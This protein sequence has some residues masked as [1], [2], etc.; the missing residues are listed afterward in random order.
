MKNIIAMIILALLVGCTSPYAPIQ[1]TY[2][3][4][5][6]NRGFTPLYQADS[7][8]TIIM[9]HGMCNHSTGWAKSR[10]ERL[11]DTM[12]LSASHTS[13]RAI[14]REFD[15]KDGKNSIFLKSYHY[16][17]DGY[18]LTAYEFTYGAFNDHRAYHFQDDDKH[19]LANREIKKLLMD[20]CLSDVTVY[21]GERGKDIRKALRH[22]LKEIE[23][24]LSADERVFFLA[25]SLGSKVLRDSLICQP[26][27]SSAANKSEQ[28]KLN[29]F[30]YSADAIILAS[31]QLPILNH[32]DSC[33][34][35]PLARR[36]GKQELSGGL[37]D[38]YRVNEELRA[39]QAD[40]GK[41][42]SSSGYKVLSFTDPNDLLSYRFKE[43]DFSTKNVQLLEIPVSNTSAFLNLLANPYKAHTGYLTNSGVVKLIACGNDDCAP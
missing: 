7:Q 38:M 40:E 19:A 5:Y 25:E 21:A 30:Y 8:T 4:D 10:V 37:L 16:A 36:S 20:D 3:D 2:R 33:K 28:S 27:N 31:N 15:T 41:S 43:S 14:S 9:I 13:N 11:A 29:R 12:N 42:N 39:K 24:K 6:Q 34:D 26:E 22:S 1:S 35:S 17:R 23:S 18:Q 32:I